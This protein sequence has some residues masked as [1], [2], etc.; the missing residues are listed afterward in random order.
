M[1][2]A[3]Y[4]HITRLTLSFMTSIVF[5]QRTPRHDSPVAVAFRKY[6][7]QFFRVF[8]PEAPPVDFIPALMYVPERWAPYKKLW[9]ESRIMQRNLYFGLLIEAEKRKN[10]GLNECFVTSLLDQQIELGLDRET[11]V[12]IG[13]AL[14]DGGAETTSSFLQNFVLCLV[15]FPAVL[16]KA[17]LE[18]DT[19]VGERIPDYN[20]IK[21][22]PYVQAIIKETHR[23][24]PIAPTAM[25][26]ASPN[27]CEYRGFVI[28][29]YTPVLFNV[30]GICRD[31]NLYERP[32]EFW[33]ER[34][35]LSPDGTKPGLPED[36]SHVRTS[37]P[38]GSGKVS[39][40]FNTRSR[41][42][43]IPGFI[44]GDKKT[45]SFFQGRQL[46][47]LAEMAKDYDGIF[48]LKVTNGTIV[49]VSNM[50]TCKELLDDRSAEFSSRPAFAGMDIVTGGRYF[51]TAPALSPQG[52]QMYHPLADEETTQLLYDILH[53]PECFYDHITRSTLS[54]ITS[55]VFGQRTP[56]Y[57]SP[58]AV[59]FMKYMEVF[60][61]VF[62]PE[63]APVD[64]IPALLYVP[65]R[66]APWKKMWKETRELQQSLYFNMFKDVIQGQRNGMYG[67]CFVAKVIEQQEELGLDQETMAYIGG[68][69]LDGGAETTA[70]LIQNLVLC[71]TKFPAAL[72]KAQMEIDSVVGERL[73]DFRDIKDLPYVQALIRET[74][75][76]LPTAPTAVP[77]ASVNDCENFMT[78][79]TN[80]GQTDTYCLLMERDPDYLRNLAIMRLLWAFD[81]AAADGSL[82][83]T[84]Q[85]NIEKEHCD[86]QT[87]FRE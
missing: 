64:F 5:G 57:N 86:I 74:H 54:F 18:V 53:N 19:V 69:L 14:L 24:L 80:S 34:Y 43:N 70:S 59:S 67:D 81:F 62:S 27:D 63:S 16:R 6:I 52:V 56:K 39:L 68:I 73:P 45:K 82:S 9:R 72:Q 26:H 44:V 49:V 10:E 87:T 77:H 12:Y 42:L 35:I 79:Q 85:L 50:K 13:G 3:F 41:I 33:P 47:W 17:Q 30:F 36:M 29:K 31:P 7:E 58:V 66:W 23:L 15:K 71:V 37:V 55:V 84:P 60:K 75:R 83:M 2:K 22:L 11:I 1:N 20:D 40:N 8:S 78:D 32:D 38:F 76:L 28:P 65:E 61:K 21:S 51:A 48:S 25:P 4:D 46:Q